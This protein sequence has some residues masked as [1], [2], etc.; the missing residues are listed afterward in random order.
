VKRK[1]LGAF[2]TDARQTLELVDKLEKGFGKG[3]QSGT[4]NWQLR[5]LNRTSSS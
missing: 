4:L 5:D 1:P 3:H 2:R